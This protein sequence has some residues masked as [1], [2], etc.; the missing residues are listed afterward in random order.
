MVAGAE[1]AA[2]AAAAV[3]ATAAA[4]FGVF[5]RLDVTDFGFTLFFIFLCL[6]LHITF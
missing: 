2:A 6:L 5:C 4:A 3:G 1:G